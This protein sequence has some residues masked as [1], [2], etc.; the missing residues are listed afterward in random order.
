MK[1]F[2]SFSIFFFFIGGVFFAAAQKS[3][4]GKTL[5]NIFPDMCEWETVALNI[6]TSIFI[7]LLLA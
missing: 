7:F 1:I 3:L 2:C 4:A 6:F 5:A